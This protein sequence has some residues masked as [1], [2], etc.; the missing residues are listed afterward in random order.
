MIAPSQRSRQADR[1]LHLLEATPSQ[2]DASAVC[3]AEEKVDDRYCGCP[4]EPPY[5]GPL[6]LVPLAPGEQR[7]LQANC[8]PMRN[9]DR[10]TDERITALSTVTQAESGGRLQ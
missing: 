2:L 4:V 8:A 9:A 3:D 7:L 5:T 10:L 1:A 6:D